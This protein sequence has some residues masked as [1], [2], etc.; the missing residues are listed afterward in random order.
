MLPLCVA[1]TPV[2]SSRGMHFLSRHDVQCAYPS[3]LLPIQKLPARRRLKPHN[4]LEEAILD[5]FLI[6]CP[7]RNRHQG[8]HTNQ[9]LN[10]RN[11]LCLY[12]PR[13]IQR[14]TYVFYLLATPYFERHHAHRCL[15][16]NI[17]FSF[18]RGISLLR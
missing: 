11:P 18:A 2:V 10:H 9:H 6:P 13:P 14:K 1:R 4:D 5:L 16:Q 3:Q 15:P 17:R 7:Y 8:Q 12:T